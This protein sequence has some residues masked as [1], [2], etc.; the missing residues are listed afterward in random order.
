M[1]LARFNDKQRNS[2]VVFHLNLLFLL[3]GFSMHFKTIPLNLN[4]QMGF[5][6]RASRILRIHTRSDDVLPPLQWKNQLWGGIDH[7]K[8]KIIHR[9]KKL[10]KH[11]FSQ[12]RFHTFFLQNKKSVNTVKYSIKSPKSLKTSKSR[13]PENKSQFIIAENFKILKILISQ[14]PKF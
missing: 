6:A 4:E 8:L 14:D 10:G 2:L 7:E 12:K 9:H 13:N 11:R 3:K 1:I 5:A